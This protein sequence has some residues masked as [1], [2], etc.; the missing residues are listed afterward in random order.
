MV[1]TGSHNWS[2]A[3]TQRNDENT[4]IIHDH[5][6]VNQYFQEFLHMYNGNG[7]SLQVAETGNDIISGIMPFPNPAENMV[8]LNFQS[9]KT[10]MGVL[11]VR[12]MAGRLVHGE[13]VTINQGSNQVQL[14]VSDAAAGMYLVAVG[15]SKPTRMVVK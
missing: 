15:N 10:Y 3:A 8:Y 4:I 11:T 5:N 12:D 9:G 6:I 1:L 14:D 13:Q 7:G 2:S